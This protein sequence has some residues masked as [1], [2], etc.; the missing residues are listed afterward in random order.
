LQ[1]HHITV[2]RTARYA[3]LGPLD[4]T[5]RDVWFVLHGYAQLAARFV[6]HFDALDDGTRLVVAPEGLSRFYSERTP[7]APGAPSR[8][9]ATWMTR[10]D[11]ES[12]IS[13]YVFYLDQL[14]ERVFERVPRES[15][16]VTVLGF[17]QGAA[18]ASRWVA[19]G[20]ARVDRL[21][22]WGGALAHDLPLGHG[23]SWL[24][25]AR[26]VLVAGSDD[27]LATPEAVRG[28]EER[29]RAHG[30]PFAVR[31]FAGGHQIHASTLLALA[32]E[33]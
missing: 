1:E 27:S 12:E 33:E 13:D 5:A 10:E 6:R 19:L 32:E 29:L 11:R 18:T 4:G 21:V 14:Y 28:E 31:R 17:S 20:T 9:G 23:G 25:G 7:D 24:R 3:T 15:A 26:L 8:V 30:V 22:C 2:A 16:R